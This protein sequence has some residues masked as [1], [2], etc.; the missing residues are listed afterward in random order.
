MTAASREADTTARRRRWPLAVLVGILAALV[1]VVLLVVPVVIGLRLPPRDF[2]T[3]LPD[4]LGTAVLAVVGVLVGLIVRAGR[5]RRLFAGTVAVV[6]VLLALWFQRGTWW[7]V[8]A[9]PAPPLLPHVPPSLT[10][11]A[12]TFVAVTVAAVAGT[13]PGR[14][15]A[16]PSPAV[17]GPLLLGVVAGAGIV[18]VVEGEVWGRRLLR[19]TF[20]APWGLSRFEWLGLLFAAVLVAGVLLGWAATATR[21]HLL[22]P[23]AAFVVVAAAAL[24]H[25][26]V[27]ALA[28]PPRTTLYGL[29]LGVLALATV[30]AVRAREG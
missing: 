22:A 10:L 25:T 7:F 14:H 21:R 28:G 17:G 1:V 27:D 15:A 8:A 6:L 20:E 11:L 12:G 23:V 26:I 24:W 5:T 4:G 13:V 18:T 3:T 19:E 29:S 2:P 16:T 9:I 30:A